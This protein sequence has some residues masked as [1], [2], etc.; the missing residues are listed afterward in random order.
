M[1]VMIEVILHYWLQSPVY[2]K[3]FEFLLKGLMNFLSRHSESIGLE[4]LFDF[5]FKLF[6]V[7]AYSFHDI[8][9]EFVS[10][11]PILVGIHHFNQ[12]TLVFVISHELAPATFMIYLTRSHFFQE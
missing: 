6:M 3:I 8:F 7:L 5:N 1:K 12:S 2:I 10:R 11:R 4:M 9:E